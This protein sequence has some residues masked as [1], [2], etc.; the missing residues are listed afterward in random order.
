MNGPFFCR[1]NVNWTFFTHECVKQGI[2]VNVKLE[3]FECEFVNFDLC[4]TVNMMTLLESIIY[5]FRLRN[6]CPEDM[7]GE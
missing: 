7:H 2:C 1:E 4:V 3:I 6:L 5:K